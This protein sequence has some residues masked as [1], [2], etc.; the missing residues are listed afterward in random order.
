MGLL[1]CGNQP[2]VQKWG[3]GLK[4]S[5]GV[6]MFKEL[7]NKKTM[8][9]LDDNLQK[10]NIFIRAER[11]VCHIV[12]CLCRSTFPLLARIRPPSNQ[13]LFT[14]PQPQPSQKEM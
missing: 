10:E 4:E 14:M 12:V 5:G 7:Q 6:M 9:K 8:Q 13:P 2:D 1:Q 3:K 11:S